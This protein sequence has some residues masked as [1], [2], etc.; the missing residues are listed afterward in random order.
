LE[1]AARAVV[2]NKAA[3]TLVAAAGTGL[4]ILAGVGDASASATNLTRTATHRRPGHTIPGAIT[5]FVP[6]TKI[7]VGAGVPRALWRCHAPAGRIAGGVQTGVISRADDGRAPGANA[8]L[9]GIAGRAGVVV[10]A[11]GPI[12]FIRIGAGSRRRIADADIVALIQRR[13]H[14]RIA[15]D[16]DPGLTSISLGAGVAVVTDGAV[17][18]G[19]EATLAIRADRYLTGIGGRG[20]CVATGAAVVQISLAI[21]ATVATGHQSGGTGKFNGS[22]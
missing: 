18:A 20:T 13:A 14:D 7:A 6:I 5:P 22:A 4:A 3:K 9:T 21:E 19:G 1:A 16:A 15:A 10:V 11:G 12:H 2:T 8:A 17:I